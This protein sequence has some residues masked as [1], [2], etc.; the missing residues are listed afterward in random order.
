MALALA[1][2]AH[3]RS[4]LIT[5]GG[6]FIGS[7]LTRLLVAAKAEVFLLCRESSDSSRL[8][9]LAGRYRTCTAD[10]LDPGAVRC[11]VRQ[12]RPDVV[13]NLAMF[14]AYPGQEDAERI[15]ATNVVGTANLIAAL[16]QYP[17]RAL[18]HAGTCLEYAPADGPIPESAPLW[19][20]GAYAVAK[21][22][23]SRLCLA[24]ARRGFPAV[25]VRLFS[26]YGPAENPMRVV[27]SVMDGCRRGEAPLVC[28]PDEVRD[29][30]HVSDVVRLLKAAGERAL[31]PG[32][33]LHAGTGVPVT[34]RGLVETIL[35]VCGSPLRPREAPARPAGRLAAGYT[36]AIERTAAL[37]GWRP[38]LDLAEGLRRTW[39]WRLAERER[40]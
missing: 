16:E 3:A 36:A 32:Q 26:T 9:D 18:V 15:H 11:A 29:F 17:P 38:A 2:A 40:P 23:A 37:T 25:I 21:R 24:L 31:P 30:I 4:V 10:L 5:G 39:A 14:G 33:V 28:F 6:G 12:V 27:P 13:Y 22:E 35:K 34:V 1:R 7:H 20:R 19:P 8:A